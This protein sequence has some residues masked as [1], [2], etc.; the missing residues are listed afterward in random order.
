M[1]ITDRKK[2]RVGIVTHNYPLYKG[3]SKD[4]GNFVYNF[5]QALAARVGKAYVFCPNYPGR[6]ESYKV[7]PVTWFSWS[8][9]DKKLGNSKWWNPNDLFRTRELLSS[10]QREIINF[11]NKNRI[12][13]LLSFWNFPGGVFACE[14]KKKTGI[15]YMTWALGSDIY[16]YPKFPIIR[17]I[18]KKVLKNANIAYGN[19][20]DI[21][22]KIQQ[23]SGVKARFLPTANS[24]RL[25][26]IKKPS[27]NKQQCNFLF[28]GR[29]ELVKGPDVIIKAVEILAKT[30]QDIH[31]YMIGEGSLKE[32]LSKEIKQKKIDHLITMLGYVEDQSVVNGYLLNCDCLVIPSR[33]ESFPL[34][35]TEALQANLPIIGSNVGDM[36]TFIP[37]NK[38]GYIFEKENSQKLAS[39][40]KKMIKDSKTI[41]KRNITRSKQLAERFKLNSIVGDFLEDVKEHVY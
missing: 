34:V 36:P 29:Q 16:I 39:L 38:L 11:V 23:I 37:K 31:L 28:L 32:A 12:D 41:K 10:G 40:M 21:C 9:G 19:S 4:A 25:E 33:S 24:L 3:Q 35:I 17:S 22:S 2:I 5:T 8:G 15:P 20:F 1:N 27:L 18:V 13:I 7:A 6:K 26:K 14:A 30:N